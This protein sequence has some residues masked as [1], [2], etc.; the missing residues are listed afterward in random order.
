VDRLV[1]VLSPFLNDG[2][3]W[4]VVSFAPLG[5]SLTH[6]ASCDLGLGLS[7]SVSLLSLISP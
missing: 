5:E 4:L 3:G 1:V 7:R 2:G 6:A